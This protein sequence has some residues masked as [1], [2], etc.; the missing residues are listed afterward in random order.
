MFYLAFICANRIT[1]ESCRQIF[2]KF[3]GGMEHVTSKDCLDFGGD[4]SPS[5]HITLEL[6]LRLDGSTT[7][8]CMRGHVSQHLFNCNSFVKSLAL[9]EG[10]ILLSVVLVLFF[11]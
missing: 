10:C 8:L 7:I 3:Y 9:V 2:L 6:R 11:D 1:Q 5:D 4:C